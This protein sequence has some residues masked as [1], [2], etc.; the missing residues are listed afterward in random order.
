[1]EIAKDIEK[2]ISIDNSIISEVNVTPPGF[3][4]FKI[5][6]SYYQSV[7]QQIINKDEYFYSGEV[8]KGKT[9]NVEF[10]SANPTGPLNVVS[11]R[12]GAYGDSLARIMNFIG[13]E[14]FKEFYVNDAG[15]QVDIL[16]ESLEI[17]YREL[18]GDP[19]EEFP[20][21]LLL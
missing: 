12:A 1:M 3:I 4:N 14:A 16:A 2:A 9:A 17:R 5:S 7:A 15:N 13:Y 19:L 10:V 18:H 8:G 11:A 20:I 21:E 6:P